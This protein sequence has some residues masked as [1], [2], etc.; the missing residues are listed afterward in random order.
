EIKEIMKS[1][2]LFIV[3][4]VGLIAT[5]HATS[6]VH[7]R[8]LIA[9]AK[10]SSVWELERDARPRE[11]IQFK[12]LLKQQRLDKLEAYFWACSDPTSEMY[13][14]F[15]TSQEVQ[16]LVRPESESFDLITQMLVDH[17]VKSEEIKHEA[18]YIHVDTST[19]VASNLFQTSFA[20]YRNYKNGKS[21]VRSVGA[22]SLP[23]WT[24]EHID[25][26]TGLTEF[27]EKR[28]KQDNY[29]ATHF[30]HVEFGDD[31]LI[32]PSVLKSY[33][34]VPSNVTGTQ[35]N[36]YQGIAAFTDYFSMGALQQFYKK[37]NIPAQ[38]VTRNGSDCFPESC[39]QYESDLD[40]Q[41]ITS[42]GQNIPTLF[43]AHSDGQWILDYAQEV[44]MMNS[45]PLVQSISYGWSE[46]EQCEIT[47]ACSTYGYSSEQYV[48]RT[49]SELQKLGV[50]GITVLV[51]DGDD[52]AP[53]LGG[54]SGNCPLDVGTYCPTGGCAH[55]KTLCSE[56]SFV[57]VSNGSVCFFPQGVESDGCN[58]VLQ[59]N[60][61][62]A[63]IAVF[64]QTNSHC[65]LA[66]ENDRSNL[67]HVYSTCTC[68]S[69][70]NITS[71]GYTISP[72]SFDLFNG[73]IFSADFPA[74]SPYITSIGA[75]QFLAR[76]GKVTQELGASILSGAKITT[77]GGFSTFQTQPSYQAKAVGAYLTNNNALPPSY[78]FNPAMRAYPDLAFNGHNYDI[79]ASTNQN[80]MD[81]CPCAS[82]PVDGTSCSSPALAGLIS[83]VNDRLLA[84]N[85]SPL[86]FM[87]PLIYQLASTNPL[88]FNDITVGSNRCNRAYCCQYGYSAAAGWDP[89]SG[90]GSID[91]EQFLQAVLVAK[92]V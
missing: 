79:I 76:N 33:Y 89:V 80:N 1:T 59:D 4:V 37:Y 69:L 26:V 41:Y 88:A 90:L 48:T 17:G 53:S 86:G 75:T 58:G 44:A 7:I 78:S 61:L 39:D 35:S 5:T 11:R 6:E 72:Y 70:Q 10:P 34:D 38:N 91:F 24:T 55:T 36:N 18:D 52:G 31:I 13:G 47:S 57:T 51:S 8:S 43:M 92:G 12:I 67:P 83:L 85:K 3:L 68:D 15:M 16:D 63:A 14:Q 81:Q 40:I 49:N 56:L 28:S 23:A 65:S 62:Y 22:V 77:G 42:M 45:P 25:F 66:F 60:N 30:D 20:L 71:N 29:A 73:P 87:N 9:E 50:M 82:L 54:A 84:N 74:S 2:I 21:R 27:V 19:S 32:T 64:N 46:I